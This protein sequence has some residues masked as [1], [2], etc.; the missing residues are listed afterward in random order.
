M[1]VLL[2]MM[3]MM[4]DYTE[5]SPRHHHQQMKRYGYH[6]HIDQICSIKVSIVLGTI[7]S[8]RGSGFRS[9]NYLGSFSEPNTP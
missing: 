8:N 2:M 3:A 6:H 1:T 9:S 7:P 5:S 4:L